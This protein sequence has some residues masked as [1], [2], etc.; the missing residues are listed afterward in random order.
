LLALVS[1]DNNEIAKKEEQR[2]QFVAGGS[3]S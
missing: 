2:R 1:P 3:K